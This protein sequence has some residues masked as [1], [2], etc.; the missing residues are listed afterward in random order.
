MHR[1]W[2]IPELLV[3]IVSFLPASDIHRA[4]HLSH[5][6]RT[7]LK[8]N[9]PPYL[10][11]LP[12]D[13]PIQSSHKQTLSQNVRDA[14]RSLGTQDATLPDQLKMA[15]TYFY[16]REAARY[17]VVKKLRPCL[18]PVLG[19]NAA[20]LIDGY[21]SLA[22]GEMKI[23]L[24]TDIPYH[25]LYDLAY[26]KDPKACN[27]LLAV[28]HP[29]AVTVFCMRGASWDSSYANVRCREY[30]GMKGYSVRVEGEHGVT[31]GDVLNELRGTLVFDGMSGGCGQDVVLVWMFDG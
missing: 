2:Q 11:P 8:A 22:E 5:Y 30:G 15:D 16:W 20:Y 27:E 10:R 9:L 3:Q 12:E 23:C 28:V 25:Q 24:Q 6:F 21:E 4:F 17:E 31:M 29:T 7:S 14:A 13:L 19:K 1:M 26:G 18:H